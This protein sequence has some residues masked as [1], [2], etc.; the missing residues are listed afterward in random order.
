[1]KGEVDRDNQHEKILQLRFTKPP[2]YT[3]DSCYQE[4]NQKLSRKNQSLHKLMKQ[5]KSHVGLK[6]DLLPQLLPHISIYSRVNPSQH[7][8]QLSS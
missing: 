6:N 2:L 7:H 8:R 4:G 3:S 1:M 5:L